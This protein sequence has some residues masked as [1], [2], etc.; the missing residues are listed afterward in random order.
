[1]NL[2]SAAQCQWSLAFSHGPSRRWGMTSMQT[3]TFF[4][5]CSVQGW[6]ADS[7]NP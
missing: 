7:C 6:A 2:I 1:M 3:Y 5:A 4:S